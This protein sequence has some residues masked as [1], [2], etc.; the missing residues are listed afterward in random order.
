MS[1]RLENYIPLLEDTPEVVHPMTHNGRICGHLHLILS[2]A[3]WEEMYA[4]GVAFYASVTDEWIEA[5]NASRL[6]DDEDYEREWAEGLRRAAKKP[7]RTKPGYVYLLKSEDGFYKIG[8]ALNVTDRSNLIGTQ[9]PQKIEVVHTFYSAD[10]C[11]AEKALHDMFRE[12]RINGEWFKL[13][14]ADV[15]HI[16]G[17]ASD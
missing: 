1:S 6:Q 16:C 15:E 2:R 12:K 5:Y 8:R 13:E 17:C 11:G 14:P 4:E 10:Y 3:A 9:M 7:R